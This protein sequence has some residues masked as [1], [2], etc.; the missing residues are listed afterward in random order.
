MLKKIFKHLI[1]FNIQ[2]ASVESKFEILADV[3]GRL[4]NFGKDKYP[5]TDVA[6]EA[7]TGICC[8]YGLRNFSYPISDDFVSAPDS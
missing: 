8:I 1:V 6:I 5:T 3:E 2:Q 4:D 7:I